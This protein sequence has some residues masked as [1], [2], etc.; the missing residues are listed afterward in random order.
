M[1]L[2]EIW[3][4]ML[5]GLLG[6]LSSKVY[7][8]FKDHYNKRVLRWFWVPL[9][10]RG[11][12]LYCGRRAGLLME[13][14]EIEPLL[15]LRD[16]LSLLEL[17]GFLKQVYAEVIIV[18]EEVNIDWSY[19]VVSLGGP[20]TNPLA[21][22]TGENNLLP[23][24]FLDLPYLKDSQ[25]LIGDKN[26]TEIFKSA[27]KENE[28]IQDVGL[29]ARIRPPQHPHTFLFLIASNYGTGTHGII[30]FL[31]STESLEELQLVCKKHKSNY[32]QAIIE[33]FPSRE[34][35]INTELLRFKKLD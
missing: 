23:L 30:K 32:F 35:V 33:T 17:K 31:T 11:I 16:A 19:P 1:S 8:Y 15:N 28:L 21:R 6:W 13:Q 27:F 3:A 26:R 20:L 10:P 24:W 7:T 22:R 14:G 18:F 12:N 4:S 9:K 29:V 25:R 34:R 5:L 2:N